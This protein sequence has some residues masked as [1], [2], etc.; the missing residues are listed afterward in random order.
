MAAAAPIAIALLGDPR[1]RQP[2]GFEQPPQIPNRRSPRLLDLHDQI[3]S[4][5]EEQKK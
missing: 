2:R 1:R 4:L 3:S 5:S